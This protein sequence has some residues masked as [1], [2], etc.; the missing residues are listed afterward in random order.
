MSL[1]RFLTCSDF[2]GD[3]HDPK[4]ARAF[5]KFA[6]LWKPDVKVFA[7]DLW[8][9]R[10]M[11]RGASDEE[12]RDS[13]KRDYAEGLQFLKEFSPDVFLLGN[14]DLRA[15]NLAESGNGLV[16]DF[17]AKLVEEIEE[18]TKKLR[19]SV[20]P[21]HKR[22]GVYRLGDLS[23]IH[24][25]AAGVGAVRK[26]A[27][28]YGNCLHGHT[29]TIESATVERQS[30]VTARSIGALCARDMAYN[31]AQIGSL[32]HA[33]GWAYGVVNDKTGA[34]QVW[35]AERVGDKFLCATD[36]VSL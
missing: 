9:F 6:E 35:Q 26:H 22:L 11:R 3:H 34:F 36:Y 20:V 21:Y 2:H 25:Y 27:M 32:R 12:K 18:E 30:P 23:M 24:G 15:W 13:L 29:H 4:T 5:L 7:G 33:N 16:S 31:A 14:H 17:A 19:C 8:D 1:R 28:V 10:A